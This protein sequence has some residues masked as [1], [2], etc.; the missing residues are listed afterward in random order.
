MFTVI[1]MVVGMVAFVVGLLGCGTWL[2]QHRDKVSAERSTRIVH[3][4]YFAGMVF[5]G[6]FGIF[7]PGLN[8]FDELFGIPS[9]PLQPIPLIVGI[10]LLVPGLYFSFASNRALPKLGDGA[11]AFL[12]TK[13]VVATDIYTRTRNPMSL[14]Y[15]LVNVGICLA[16]GSTVL[17]LGCLCVLIPAHIF[18]LKFFE[19]LELELRLGEPYLEYKKRVSFLIPGL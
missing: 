8:H 12:L 18:F 13:R 6:V 19:E 1:L 9:L 15:Y 11:A 4:L 16:V 10:L 2:R 7:Y 3:F 17:T 14:G 5:P